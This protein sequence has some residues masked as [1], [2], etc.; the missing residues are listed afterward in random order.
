MRQAFNSK[1]EKELK[2][3]RKEKRETKTEFTPFFVVLI[4]STNRTHKAY[5]RHL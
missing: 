2:K 5:L 1:L 4:F 3:R